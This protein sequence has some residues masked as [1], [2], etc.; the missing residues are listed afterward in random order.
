M[1]KKTFL[2]IASSLTLLSACKKSDSSSS[3]PTTQQKIQA[4][5]HYIST[6]INNYYSGSPHVVTLN[7][8]AAD[9]ADF[10][11]DNKVYSYTAGAYDTSAYTIINDTKMWI[12]T[13]QDEYEIKK[14]TTGDFILYNKETISATEYTET[15]ITLN[16]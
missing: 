10:R 15:T 16:K 1:K 6:V 9:Y 8:N 3:Q 11:N 14:L 2:L 5:W 7:G 12:D 4:K 13:P